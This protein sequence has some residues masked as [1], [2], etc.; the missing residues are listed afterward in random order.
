MRILAILGDATG[1]NLEGERQILEGLP[2]AEIV[3]TTEPTATEL[4]TLLGQD[5]GWDIL[6]FAGHISNEGIFINSKEKITLEG[7][8]SALKVASKHGLKL[9]IFNGCDGLVLVSDL[10]EWQIPQVIAMREPTPDA[11]AQEFFKYF[12][13][14]FLEGKS[15]YLSVREA[16]ERLKVIEDRFPFSSSLPVIIQN[17]AAVPPTWQ[18]FL[19]D[20]SS[21]TKDDRSS[22]T[23]DDRISPIKRIW[24]NSLRFFGFQRE[25]PRS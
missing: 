2:D 1:I 17:P 20:S 11:V 15:L 23:K 25:T 9:G 16:R 24:H 19:R 5:R 21:P 6:F 7:L 8:S 18:S 4:I 3:F 12:M 13:A 10:S 14:A 22:P